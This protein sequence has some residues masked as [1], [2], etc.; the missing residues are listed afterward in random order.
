[1]NEANSKDKYQ[2][3]MPSKGQEE[4][5]YYIDGLYVMKKADESCEEKRPSRICRYIDIKEVLRDSDTGTINLKIS[6]DYKGQFKTIEVPR[7]ILTRNKILA[8][9]EYGIDIVDDQARLKNL[10][11]YLFYQ[12]SIA[13]MTNSHSSIGLGEVDG[14]LIYK[15]SSAIGY[16]SKY[17]GQ[18][19]LEPHGTLEGWYDTIRNHVMGWT[20]WN[21]L[22][23][24]VGASGW[25][26]VGFRWKEKAIITNFPPQ[27][28]I[29]IPILVFYWFK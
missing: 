18:L 14:K 16:D 6:F 7:S 28:A 1:M 5:R 20:P 23:Q 22:I 12:E 4:S 21:S 3:N 25:T 9:I 13:P 2:I 26:Y 8:L 15:L 10:L 11:Q 27:F 19:D 24:L 29:I 17:S